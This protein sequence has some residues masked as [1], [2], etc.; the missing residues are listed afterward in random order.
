M[1]RWQGNKDLDT[2]NLDARDR[3]LLQILGVIVLIVGVLLSLFG[4]PGF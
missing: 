2:V 3:R 1:T 4:L